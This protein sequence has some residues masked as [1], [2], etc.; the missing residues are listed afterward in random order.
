MPHSGP[1]PCRSWPVP[2]AQGAG[3]WHA[4]KP[5]TAAD[6]FRHRARCSPFQRQHSPF[7]CTNSRFVHLACGTS[8]STCPRWSAPAFPIP[9]PH[10]GHWSRQPR[11]HSSFSTFSRRSAPSHPIPIPQ[12]VHFRSSLNSHSSFNT[13]VWPLAPAVAIPIPHSGHFRGSPVV[14]FLIQGMFVAFGT[15]TSH[16][17][18]SFRTFSRRSGPPF[19][20]PIP[21]SG[22]FRAGRDLRSPFPFLIQDIFAPVGAYISHSHS[23]FS[24]FLR[25]SVPLVPHS[26]SSFSTFSRRSGPAFPTPIPH[27][28]HSRSGQGLH[29]PFPFLIQDIFAVVGTCVPRSHS[30][31]RTV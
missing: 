27:A 26:H 7:A 23:S 2:S 4:P 16:C 11:S 15:P 8:L 25:W 1:A 18:S 19:P 21:H 20:I 22:H 31:F 24:T 17:H 6:A 5:Q 29:S 30:S 28:G 9:T 14:Q 10:S 13:I 3:P 12:S